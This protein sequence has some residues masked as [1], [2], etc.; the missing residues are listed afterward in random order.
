MVLGTVTGPPPPTEPAGPDDVDG[1]FPAPCVRWSSTSSVP[2]FAVVTKPPML[3]LAMFHSEKVIGM[4]ASTSILPF[5]ELG[6]DR[7][8]SPTSSRRACR[9]RPPRCTA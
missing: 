2:V 8:A 1:G 9:G 7:E 5:H 6:G 3:G 4:S